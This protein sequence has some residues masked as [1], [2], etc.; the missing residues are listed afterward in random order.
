MGLREFRDRHGVSWKVW[1]VTPDYLDKRTTAE[2]YMRDWQDGW[3]CFES[4]DSRRRLANFPP[5]WEALPEA[6]L[7]QLLHRSQVVKRRDAGSAETSGEFARE[8]E[9]RPREAAPPDSERTTT[10]RPEAGRMTPPGGMDTTRT[11]TF[12]DR[13]GRSFVAGLYRIQPRSEGGKVPTSAGTVLRFLSGSIAL[14]LE[15]WPDDWDRYSDEQL[16]L[17]L[18]R[19][20]PAEPSTIGDSLPVRRKT[21]LPG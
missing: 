5:G 12:V 6:G 1:D 4:S 17:L 20:Q 15:Q 10:S 3:L 21:D 2:D 13:R 7:E 19:A 8:S 14:D 18:E 11:R 9:Q 16:N